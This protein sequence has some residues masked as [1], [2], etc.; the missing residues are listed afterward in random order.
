MLDMFFEEGSK[1]LY[2]LAV[3]CLVLYTE[4]LL[5]EP[6]WGPASHSGGRCNCIAL[7]PA[8]FVQKTLSR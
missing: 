8:P 3:T 5:G 4:G 7:T 6:Q 2:R 1:V